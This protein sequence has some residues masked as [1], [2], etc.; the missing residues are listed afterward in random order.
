MNASVIE[1]AAKAGY[2]SY[3]RDRPG[4][5]WSSDPTQLRWLVVTARVLNGE[6]TTSEDLHSAYWEGF[7]AYLVPAWADMKMPRRM[8]WRETL[9]A[10]QRHLEPVPKAAIPKREPVR[11]LR[12]K[13]QERRTA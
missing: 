12:E 10:I 8:L 7:D 5:V 11:L 4:R 2:A 1:D 3:Y 9:T 13:L 6:I